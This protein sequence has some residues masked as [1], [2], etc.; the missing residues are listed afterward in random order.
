MAA[1]DPAIDA[2]ENEHERN[3][4]AGQNG[5]C[6]AEFAKHLSDLKTR[7]KSESFK[8]KSV[9]TSALFFMSQERKHRSGQ[10]FPYN[11]IID[12]ERDDRRHRE[13]I[14][15]YV[16]ENAHRDLR[17]RK[18]QVRIRHL[19]IASD[20][21]VTESRSDQSAEKSDDHGHDGVMADQLTFLYSQS[22]Q[23]TDDF[24]LIVYL[25]DDE[26]GDTICEESEDNYTRKETGTLVDL[27]IVT[28]CSDSHIVAGSNQL[29]QIMN[30]R[31]EHVAQ[32]I[33][34]GVV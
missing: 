29:L 4:K 27:H 24:A 18:V 22:I 32:L 8:L 3:R 13:A 5:E 28:G 1:H 34:V 6:A 10:L 31:I 15:D 21:T 19:K 9:D 20:R 26:D 7:Y 23:C 17:Y 14:D 25:M 30:V 16:R 11:Q 2:D 33:D 12:N